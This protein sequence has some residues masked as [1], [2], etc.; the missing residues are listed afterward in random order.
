MPARETFEKQFALLNTAQID[1][2]IKVAT[3]ESRETFT[4][5]RN[6]KDMV[7]NFLEAMEREPLKLISFLIYIE[8]NIN[9]P[10]LKGAARGYRD[11]LTGAA[12]TPG[13]AHEALII[14]GE[15]FVDRTSFRESLR[16]FFLNPNNKI[17]VTK[18]EKNTGRSH[19]A[20]LVQHV[21][22][23]FG[24]DVIMIDLLKATIPDIV[25]DFISILDLPS[26]EF[27]DRMAQGSTQTKGFISA[28][29][30][31]TAK[32]R[33]DG[34][35]WC[36]VFDH[37]DMDEVSPE[38]KVF[39]ESLA[40]EE[41]NNRLD[42]GF[43]VFLGHGTW[44]DFPPNLLFKLMAVNCPHLEHSDIESYIRALAQSK[45][46]EAVTEAEIQSR[47]EAVFKN[48]QTPLTKRCLTEMANRLRMYF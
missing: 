11:L 2:I 30:G 9:I 35:T 47:K 10:A 48:L 37:H 18:G 28:F 38:V 5:H 24:F 25:N 23:D 39:A 12:R 15:P 42:N 32:L 1:K 45:M 40:I 36:V 43:V 14:W 13:N 17:L 20:L 16:A 31:Q 44:I 26:T 8:E 19:A 41:A 29:K 4:T 33:Q 6:V 27:R 46:E 21:A 7:F 22:K 3:G 34:R